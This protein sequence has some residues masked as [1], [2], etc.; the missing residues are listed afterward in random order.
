MRALPVRIHNSRRL[1]SRS[2]DG[3]G[4]ATT[5]AYDLQTGRFRTSQ[6]GTGNVIV[7]LITLTALS[8]SAS[9]WIS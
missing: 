2:N 6:A 9:L 8:G 1:G 5:N 7:N 3:S 4:I